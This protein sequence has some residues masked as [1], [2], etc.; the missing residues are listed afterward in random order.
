MS[1][2]ESERIESIKIGILGG[3]SFFLADIIFLLLN[4]FWLAKTWQIFLYFQ[5][6]LDW[7][8]AIQ[9]AIAFFSGFLFAVTYRYIIRADQNSHLKDGAV[10]AFGLVRGL[11]FVETADNFETNFSVYLILVIETIVNFLI[12][13][14]I[15][16]FAFFKKIIKPFI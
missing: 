4:N 8:L 9:L 15:L 7:N 13:R 14:L 3:L 5:L 12:T 11:V 2:I 1:Y 10:L 6:N 16:D